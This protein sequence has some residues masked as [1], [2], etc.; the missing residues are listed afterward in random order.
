M[1][2]GER[3]LQAGRHRTRDLE[4][5]VAPVVGILRMAKPLVLDGHAPGKSDLP[6]DDDGAAVI[7]AM[8]ARPTAELRRAERRDAATGLLEIVEALVGCPD[9]RQPVEQHADLDAVLLPLDAF[10]SARRR[11]V[12]PPSGRLPAP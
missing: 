6:V 4:H 8:E 9:R 7:A 2:G 5:H 12:R 10:R 11:A 1:N 3:R